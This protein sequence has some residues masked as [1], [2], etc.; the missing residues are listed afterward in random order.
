MSDMPWFLQ[1]MLGLIVFNLSTLSA[2]IFWLIIQYM[3]GKP[4]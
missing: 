3:R 1:A 4:L 2:F